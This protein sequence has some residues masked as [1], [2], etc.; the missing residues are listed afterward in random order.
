MTR[1]GLQG[2]TQA[3]QR[4]RC[5]L[6]DW[7]LQPHCMSPA[8]IGSWQPEVRGACSSHLVGSQ[9]SEH[10]QVQTAQVQHVAV[11]VLLRGVQLGKVQKVVVDVVVSDLLGGDS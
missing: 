8:Q 7:K 10:S 1:E 6:G 2:S 9:A 5:R 4:A 3:L 11:K